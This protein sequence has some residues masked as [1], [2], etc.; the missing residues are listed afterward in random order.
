MVILLVVG[1]WDVVAELSVP[2]GDAPWW[3]AIGPVTVACLALL[4]RRRRPLL[5]VGIVLATLA[6]PGFVTPTRL[7]YWGEYVVWLV[8]MYSVG[9]HL[10]WRRGVWAIPMSLVAYG[11]ALAHYPPM[12][13]PGDVLFN[14][15]VLMGLWALGRLA[16][17]WSAYRDRTLLLE[18]DRAQ[19]EERA[20]VRERTRIARELH[21]VISHT[22]TVIVVQAG[23]ARLASETDPRA[24]VDALA[25]IEAL[26]RDSLAELRALLDVLRDD[27]E[28]VGTAPQPSLADVAE[29]C[30]RMRSLGLP[31]TVHTAGD[32]EAVAS[33]VQLV[34]YRIVQE[35]LTNVLKHA[36]TVDTDVVIDHDAPA[37][38]VLRISSAPGGEA[39]GLPG[40]AHGLVG[41]RERVDALGGTLTT[42]RRPDGGFVL[43][44]RLPADVSPVSERRATRSR[45]SEWSMS[46]ATGQEG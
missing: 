27:A 8:A 5:T 28:E 18:F 25:R 9:R 38:L 34:A 42:H 21:D 30:D 4:L 15:A 35:G 17:S 45:M 26:G 36:G 3:T 20:E 23:G 14:L 29:L 43:H 46:G 16:A 1:M 19:A 32:L 2:Y 24:A 40:A 12:R 41:L 31:V 33:I 6:L 44:A 11:S 39:G 7:T 22:I 37:E 10:P 13:A